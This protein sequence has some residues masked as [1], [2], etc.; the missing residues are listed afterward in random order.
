MTGF[1]EQLFLSTSDVSEVSNTAHRLPLMFR[2]LE[3]GNLYCLVGSLLLLSLLVASALSIVGVEGLLHLLGQGAGWC[4]LVWTVHSSL[5]CKLQYDRC[6][7]KTG[8]QA[9]L[10]GMCYETPCAAIT[11]PADW[12]LL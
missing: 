1:R 4:S 8:R 5:L 7:L 12:S 10:A 9:R 11:C 2:G 6:C 3:N